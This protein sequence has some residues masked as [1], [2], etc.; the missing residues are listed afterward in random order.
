MDL[1]YSQTYE[2]F[3]EEVRK[4]LD[5]QKKDGSV[6]EYSM[7]SNPNSRKGEPDLILSV[8]YA[9]WAAFDLGVEYFEKLSSKILGSTEKSRTAN[10]DRGALRE[11]GS[12]FVLQEIKFK[13]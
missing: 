6:V 7:Y 3:R 5:T 13:D 4:F 11:I 1:A 2:A 12:T 10:I 9:N 8:T